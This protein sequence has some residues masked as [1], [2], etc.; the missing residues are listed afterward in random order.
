[1]AKLII[2]P[3]DSTVPELWACG[4]EDAAGD[5]VALL[6]DHCSCDT[7]WSEQIRKAHELSYSVVGGAVENAKTGQSSLDWA[8]YFYDYGKYMLPEAARVVPTLSASNVSYKREALQQIRDRYRQGFHPTFI[9]EELQ[10]RGYPL[11]LTPMAIVYHN[12]NYALRNSVRDCYHHG[13]LFAAIRLSGAS[14]LRRAVRGASSVLLPVVLPARIAMNAVHKKRRLKELLS[15]FPYLL[16]LMS[17]WS[18]GEFCG[19]LWRE[20]ASARQWR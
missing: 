10:K 17:V 3:A 15:C 1:V 2:L 9:N 6:E 14:A 18:Y 16:L 20:G 4:V 13:R 12:K 7:E 8:V 19:Y 5:I 11:Y